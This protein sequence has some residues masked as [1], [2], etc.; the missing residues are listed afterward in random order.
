VNKSEVLARMGSA[1]ELPLAVYEII[2]TKDFRN[3]CDAFGVSRNNIEEAIKRPDDYQHLLT[4]GIPAD[5]RDMSLF[6]KGVFS[7]EV[8]KRHWLLVQCHRLGSK[9]TA[10]TAWRLYPDEVDLKE[11]REPL[12]ALRAFVNQFGI[13]I[14]VGDK[15]GLFVEPQTF[16]AGVPVKVD[17]TGA[18]KEHF[19][20]SIQITTPEGL[21]RIGVTYCID[22][23]KYR[24][25]LKA[26]GVRVKDTGPFV[27]RVLEHVRTDYSRR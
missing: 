20:S 26:H 4:E 5:A 1:G 16:P 10:T 27:H 17:W 14:V 11:A 19:L 6:M 25:A 24:T 18:P 2:Q 8:K 23:G 12:D 13:P 22:L 9:Q 15:H 3:Y 7:R 21:F